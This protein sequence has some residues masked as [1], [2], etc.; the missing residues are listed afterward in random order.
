MTNN[1]LNFNREELLKYF[2]ASIYF[3]C[4]L[5]IILSMSSLNSVE[6]LYT[7]MDSNG[8]V[9]IVWQE[10]TS[11]GTEIK[12][13]ALPLASVS[14]E[15]PV[16]LS[17]TPVSSLPLIAVTASGLDTLAVAIWAENNGGAVQL[18]GAMRLSLLSSWS[19][20][21]M[22]SD[23]IEDVLGGYELVMNPNGEIIA[24]WTSI[25]G[26]NQNLR[27][28]RTLINSGNTWG[29]PLTVN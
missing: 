9:Q 6:N 28:S 2:Q 17:T 5:I 14:W 20:G 26:I 12:A 11:F 22:I 21:V 19:P 18:Y 1:V 24:T 10:N 27:S 15:L 13:S 16:I 25:D 7:G 29:S 3:F 23:G 4:T 8:N